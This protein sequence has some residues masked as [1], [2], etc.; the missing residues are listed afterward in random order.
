MME[1]GKQRLAPD[2]LDEAGKNGAPKKKE[3]PKVDWLRLQQQ[4]TVHPVLDGRGER[5]V[6]SESAA[7]QHRGGLVL[8]THARLFTLLGSATDVHSVAL[9]KPGVPL[10]GIGK[11]AGGHFWPFRG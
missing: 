7:T 4:R 8:K 10:R 1:F 9:G 3:R 11:R 5:I 2:E 6:I